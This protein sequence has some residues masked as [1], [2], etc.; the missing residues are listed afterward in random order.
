MMDGANAMEEQAV[1]RREACIWNLAC[2]M[3]KQEFFSTDSKLTDVIALFIILEWVEPNGDNSFAY[4]DG[5]SNKFSCH[6]QS[7]RHLEI[8]TLD[9]WESHM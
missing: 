7:C 3:R 6:K 2:M 8:E 4:E 5:T 1:I 9:Q